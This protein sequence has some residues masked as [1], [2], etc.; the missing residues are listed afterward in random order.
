MDRRT[1]SLA[2]LLVSLAASSP[3]RQNTPQTT[4]T[5]QYSLSGI[6]VNGATGEPIPRALVHLNAQ[7]Q[8]M[9][10]SGPDG[11][12]EFD[13]LPAGAAM[14]FGQK[15][16]FYNQQ[17]MGLTSAPIPVLQI[18]RDTEIK[19]NLYPMGAIAGR[20]TGVS[21]DP[22]EGIDVKAIYQHVVDGTVFS[23]QRNSAITDDSG[24]YRIANLVPGKYVVAT[25][26]RPVRVLSPQ[27]RSFGE[28]FDEVYPGVYFP[29]APDASG[30]VPVQVIPGQQEEANFSET[31]VKA[32]S[33]SGTVSGDSSERM[34]ISLNNRDG[35]QITTRIQR[36]GNHFKFL[37][38][39]P[40]DYSLFVSAGSDTNQNAVW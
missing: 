2:F 11:R 23:D 32:Y 14:V 40:G 26:T 16:G 35:D 8:Q 7:S 17:E 34:F 19:V 9:T 25:A 10:M 33:V 6:V 15:P 4:S 28:N 30:A 39:V 1:L 22:I 3:G 20:V 38:I 5:G 24:D 37:D 27:I 18:G 12:F 13:N 31:P 21:G 29:G 36:R